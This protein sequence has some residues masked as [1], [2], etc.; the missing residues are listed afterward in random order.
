MSGANNLPMSG[1]NNLPMSGANL[2]MSGA[3]F[4]MFSRR[5]ISKQDQQVSNDFNHDYI[6]SNTNKAKLSASSLHRT[7]MKLSKHYGKIKTNVHDQFTVLD[8]V[9]YIFTRDDGR[10]VARDENSYYIFAQQRIVETVT[11]LCDNWKFS[12]SV[13]RV[14]I[15]LSCSILESSTTMAIFDEEKTCFQNPNYELELFKYTLEFVNNP[16]EVVYVLYEPEIYSDMIVKFAPVRG[17][18]CIFH[19]SQDGTSRVVCYPS[20]NGSTTNVQQCQ[21]V[22]CRCHDILC[23]VYL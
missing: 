11:T 12:E 10:R 3:N 18:H 13:N 7:I 15:A 4:L 1:A 16:D 5:S 8:R 23:N 14:K 9:K 17:I 6:A 20:Q 19:V 21:V 22:A 2:P